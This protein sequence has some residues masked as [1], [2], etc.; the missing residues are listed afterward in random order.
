[1]GQNLI[2]SSS[3]QITADFRRLRQGGVRLGGAGRNRTD[4]LYN[5][6][7]ALSQLSYG[8][9]LVWDGPALIDRSGPSGTDLRQFASAL[10]GKNRAL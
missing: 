8:P 9:D 7:V 4:D 3:Q 6:I 2:G 10:Q 1:M 5:A